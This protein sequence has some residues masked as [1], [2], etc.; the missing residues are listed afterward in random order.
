[1][2]VNLWSEKVK[3]FNGSKKIGINR[4]FLPH[5]LTNLKITL[6]NKDFGAWDIS[7]D[8]ISSGVTDT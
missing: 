7:T 1:M 6:C 3:A 5:F 4:K 2:W 8:S